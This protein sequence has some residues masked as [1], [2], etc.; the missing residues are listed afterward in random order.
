[1]VHYKP[2]RLE[3]RRQGKSEQA[4][5]AC[6]N[7]WS[8]E[9]GLKLSNFWVSAIHS[10]CATWWR[11]GPSPT[12]LRQF[13]TRTRCPL[14]NERTFVWLFLGIETTRILHLK[15]CEEL[16]F[17]ADKSREEDLH[18]GATQDGDAE[19]NNYRKDHLMTRGYL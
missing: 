6:A 14:T 7:G 15:Q 2:R 8:K 19:L 3:R 16:K 13:F 18:A 11:K 10:F 17:F 5:A 1:V 12:K 4:V 9:D